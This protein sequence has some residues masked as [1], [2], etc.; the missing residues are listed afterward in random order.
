[1]RHMSGEPNGRTLVL[2]PGSNKQKPGAA[3]IRR[4]LGTEAFACNSGNC[5]AERASYGIDDVLRGVDNDGESRNWRLAPR[6]HLMAGFE[7]RP[8]SSGW[9]TTNGVQAKRDGRIRCPRRS[10]NRPT[11]SQATVRQSISQNCPGFRNRD[12]HARNRTIENQ[13][14]R[15]AT[16]REHYH[17]RF[18]VR[19]SN[20]VRASEEYICFHV[21]RDYL[22]A[23]QIVVA[24]SF[25]VTS[26][27]LSALC[28][29][30]EP[31][32]APQRT[33]PRRR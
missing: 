5:W 8:Q 24:P 13:S 15:L 1:M 21:E 29:A 2:M 22:P 17:L 33:R 23:A 32:A 14:A 25:S 6:V 10:D 26:P 3:F 11:G 16:R 27:W 30:K 9:I 7:Q 28:S 19:L 20:Q 18:V 4:A 12:A 31:R